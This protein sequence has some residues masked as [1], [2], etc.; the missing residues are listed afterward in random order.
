[1]S[2]TI[3]WKCLYPQ[4]VAQREFPQIRTQC[5]KRRL[6]WEAWVVSDR[7][8]KY[9]KKPVTKGTDSGLAVTLWV[10]PDF[11]YLPGVG[12]WYPHAAELL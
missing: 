10:Y 5:T 6:E 11:A 2:L 1:M 7:K 4:I 8:H 9:W 12:L 3:K